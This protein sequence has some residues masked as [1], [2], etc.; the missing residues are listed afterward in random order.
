[1]SNTKVMV[2]SKPLWKKVSGGI[3]PGPAADSHRGAHYV[4]SGL[5]PKPEEGRI[6]ESVTTTRTAIPRK[7]CIGSKK[8]I[9]LE[10]MRRFKS[11]KSSTELGLKLQQPNRQRARG[12]EYWSKL[13]SQRWDQDTKKVKAN[14]EIK[15]NTAQ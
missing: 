1:M 10:V 2:S 8:I 6:R 3:N 11:Q 5:C 4:F 12:K 15:L 14:I 13:G 7:F 9:D